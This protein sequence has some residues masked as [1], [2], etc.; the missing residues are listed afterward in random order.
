MYVVTLV[1][2]PICMWLLWFSLDVK[3]ILGR[4]FP[5]IYYYDIMFL[6]QYHAEYEVVISDVLSP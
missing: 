6:Q 3:E 4:M 2:A 1:T 5:H